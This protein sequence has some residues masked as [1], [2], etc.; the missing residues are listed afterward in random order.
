MLDY[1]GKNQFIAPIIEFK[2][3]LFKLPQMSFFVVQALV[4]VQGTN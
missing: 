3:W 2:K 1:Q 4:V